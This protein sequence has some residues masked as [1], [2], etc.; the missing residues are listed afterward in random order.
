MKTKPWMMLVAMMA[1]WINR[2]QQEVIEYLKAENSILKDEL[3]RATGR[4]IILLNDKQRR[5][6]SLGHTDRTNVLTKASYVL[7][8]YPFSTVILVFA[9]LYDRKYFCSWQKQVF[10]VNCPQV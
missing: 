6:L 4:K 7:F 8:E 9:I 1:G 2:Q 3:L 5:W 10:G